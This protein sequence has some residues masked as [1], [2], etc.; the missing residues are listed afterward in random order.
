MLRA[1]MAV[2]ELSDHL[3]DQVRS[4]W[5]QLDQLD[6]LDHWSMLDLAD[7]VVVVV[8]IPPQWAKIFD[9]STWK[10]SQKQLQKQHLNQINKSAMMISD[11]V[12]PR[13]LST[14]RTWSEPVLELRF[15]YTQIHRLEMSYNAK[16]DTVFVKLDT[17]I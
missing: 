14:I 12:E 13:F 8:N 9:W 11:Q 16:S 3:S 15:E 5:D 17:Q 2:N 7:L 1:I 10:L 4:S 6:Q